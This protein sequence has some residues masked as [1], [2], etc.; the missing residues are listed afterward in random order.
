MWTTFTITRP[1][2]HAR[3]TQLGGG[4][5][6]AGEF[7]IGEAALD[8]GLILGRPPFLVSRSSNWPPLI[9]T[10]VAFASLGIAATESGEKLAAASRG[11]RPHTT[12]S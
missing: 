2:I 12:K 3:P 6:R 4:D 9:I 7:F 11:I 8:L 5:V 1:R 10:I